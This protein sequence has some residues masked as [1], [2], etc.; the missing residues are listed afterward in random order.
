MTAR[1][2]LR[3]LYAAETPAAAYPTGATLLDAALG[4]GWARARVVNL[5]GDR[6]TGKTL[7]AIEACANFMRATKGKGRVIYVEVEHAFDRPYA[8]SIGFPPDALLVTDVATVEALF[9]RLQE[10][11]KGDAA[12]PVPT[13]VVVDS[14]DA[15]SDEGENANTL[16]DQGYGAKKPKLLSEMFRR[17]NGQLATQDITLFIISQVRE[18]IGVTFGAKYTR[19][20][21][22]A[23]D[24]YASQVVWLSET[25]KI[26]KTVH[27]ITRPIGAIVRARVTKNKIG[28]PFREI[29]LR[30]LYHYGM[31]DVHTSLF[32]LKATAEPEELANLHLAR[33]VVTQDLARLTDTAFQEQ[34]RALAQATW[35]RVETGFALSTRKYP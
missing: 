15:L 13:L 25:E 16:G 5:V 18:N 2:P 12:P 34:V 33:G 6:S 27:G 7:L 28:P 10:W 23:L 21:G 14:L 1:V 9:A 29:D 19:S 3:N 8:E 17:L 11:S 4:G 24:F 32:W 22:K 20:G 30:V 35:Q 26:K 31:D